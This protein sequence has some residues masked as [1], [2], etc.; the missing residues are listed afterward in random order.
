MRL[1]KLISMKKMTSNYLKMIKIR[2]K[3]MKKKTK[4]RKRQTKSSGVQAWR[5]GA[6]DA[7]VGSVDGSE[8]T[9]G[10]GVRGVLAPKARAP[11]V[12]RR[13]G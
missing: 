5:L 13:E 6:L 1:K 2:R 4:R 9:S 3:K 12:G 11:G 8:V 7:F 10:R